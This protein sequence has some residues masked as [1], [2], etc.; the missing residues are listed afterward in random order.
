MTF[1]N[2][3]SFFRTKITYAVLVLIIL[4]LYRPQ[5]ALSQQT[6]QIRHSQGD[7]DI[8]HSYFSQIISEVLHRTEKEYGSSELKVSVENLTQKRSLH[9]V[10]IGK[11]IDLDW[12]GTN[13]E[14][15]RTLRAI[16]IPLNLGLL[17]YRLL[18]I[19]KGRRT[20]FDQITTPQQLKKLIACQGQHWPD[21]DIL[22]DNGYTV[23]RTIRFEFM[24][25][26]I[27][28]KRCDYFPR[29]ISEGYGE[30][31]HFGTNKFLAYDKLLLAYRFPMYFFVNKKDE[32]LAL[33]FE[34]GLETMLNDGSLLQL[35]K[36]HPATRSAF[37]LT[38]YQNSRIFFMQN[39]FLTPETLNLPNKYW[40]SLEN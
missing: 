35:M 24:W 14:R 23:D 26:M 4:V 18:V 38:Q 28:K 11:E 3:H 5:A 32:Q 8:A 2:Q 17:G 13:K 34:K 6:I 22:E 16:R 33:R 36:E 25:T 30:T 12:A 15:E 10:E 7:G 31:E 1:G 21:S 37:P 19:K 40:L 20:E 29:A 27:D 9:F 39:N